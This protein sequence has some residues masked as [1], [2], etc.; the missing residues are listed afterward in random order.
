MLEQEMQGGDDEKKRQMSK[1]ARLI[2]KAINF[3][4]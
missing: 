4:E 3:D 1:E 2:E